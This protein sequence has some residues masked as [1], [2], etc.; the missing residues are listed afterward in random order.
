MGLNDLYERGVEKIGLICAD[1]LKGLEVVISEVFTG[2]KLQR[3]TTHLKRNILSD[4]RKGNKGEVADDLRQ[5]FR[6]GDRNYTV[7]D[8]WKEWQNFCGKWGRYYRKI[9][10]RGGRSGVQSILHLPELR[11]PRSANDIHDKL[12]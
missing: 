5:V 8:A 10:A 9:K 3:C 12:D 7:E 6:T 1:G 11:S 2:T 4:V